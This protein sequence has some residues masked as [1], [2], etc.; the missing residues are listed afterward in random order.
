MWKLKRA[1]NMEF[2]QDQ[3]GITTLIAWCEPEQGVRVDIMTDAYEPIMSFLGPEHSVRLSVMRFLH[4]ESTKGILGEE[5]ELTNVVSLEHAG[6]LA[7][8]IYRASIETT[9]YVQF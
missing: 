5:T 9:N 1:D 4:E 7:R 2:E 3:S 8:E 6:Y